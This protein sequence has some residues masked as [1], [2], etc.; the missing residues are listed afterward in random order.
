MCARRWARRELPARQRSPAARDR[1]RPQQRWYRRAAV[2]PHHRVRARSRWSGQAARAASLRP[3]AR[4]RSASP[5]RYADDDP[6][7]DRAWAASFDH[8]CQVTR[9]QWGTPRWQADR[10]PT[11]HLTDSGMVDATAALRSDG[12]PEPALQ[13]PLTR[14]PHP[15]CEYRPPSPQPHRPARRAGLR[16]HPGVRHHRLNRTHKSTTTTGPGSASLRRVASPRRSPW[17]HL[18]VRLRVVGRGNQA[19]P[20]GPMELPQRHVRGRTARH[21]GAVPAETH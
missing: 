9:D 20:M 16:R 5:A 3:G 7:Q 1:G 21:S 18:P 12:P 19:G 10:R 6:F 4:S 8:Y 11:A 13:R 15:A 17:G 14:L 2:R